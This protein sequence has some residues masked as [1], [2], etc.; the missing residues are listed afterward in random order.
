MVPGHFV[1]LPALPLTPSGKVD[2]RALPAPDNTETFSG[3]YVAPRTLTEE[4]LCT[5]WGGVLSVERVSAHDNFFELGGHSLLATQVVS[6]IRKS[7]SIELPLRTLFESSTVRELAQRVD[8]LR[9]LDDGL[10]AP[11][12]RHFGR[13]GALPLSFAQQRLWFY[14]QFESGD[15]IYNLMV[16]ARM[17]GP[18][19]VAALER[20]LNE[21]VRRHEALRT[22]FTTAAGQ[23][24]QVI[25]PTLT[26][27]L[28]VVDLQELPETVRE[29]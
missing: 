9:R 22:S 8:S 29:A 17:T 24:I 25:A 18:L 11:P 2:R 28:E 1:A 23:P 6:R 4:L 5:I 27:T 16:V 26:L 15:A 14:S 21:I 20:S 13:D 7:F 19:N 12:L 10:A 3:Q